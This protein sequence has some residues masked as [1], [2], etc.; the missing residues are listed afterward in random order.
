MKISRTT[1][2]YRFL[3]W[4]G[5]SARKMPTNLCDYVG[6]LMYYAVA[7]TVKWAVIAMFTCSAVCFAA[8]IGALMLAAPFF[9]LT[10]WNPLGWE[11][12]KGMAEAGA[13]I[14]SIIVAVITMLGVMI[15]R[16]E[17]QE[18][19]GKPDIFMHRIRDW[20][21]KRCTLVEYDD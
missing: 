7:S 9:Y 15:M 8:G 18:R 4:H 2:H 13:W 3:R 11:D 21:E 12:V 16:W 5:H 20:R 6:C 19:S 1:W 10:N 14:W 17:Y